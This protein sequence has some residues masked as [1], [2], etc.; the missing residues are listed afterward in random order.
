MRRIK[1]RLQVAYLRR[2][3]ALLG[4]ILDCLAQL[5]NRLT[6]LYYRLNAVHASAETPDRYQRPTV[7]RYD[8]DNNR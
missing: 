5:I 4:W 8:R 2:Q 1:L 7:D 6:I 3:H